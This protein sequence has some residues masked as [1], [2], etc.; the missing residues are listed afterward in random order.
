M[1]GSGSKL[2]KIQT[3]SHPMV[4]YKPVSGRPSIDICSQLPR[5]SEEGRPRENGIDEAY[6]TTD[7]AKRPC[8]CEGFSRAS[9]KQTFLILLAGI[10][11]MNI[12]YQVYWFLR[13]LRPISCNCGETVSEAIANGCRYDSFAAAWL[14]P[15]CRNDELIDRFERAGPNP[16][17]SWPYYGNKNKTQ[18]LSLK[19]VSMLPETGGHFFTTHQWHLVHCAYYWKKMFLAVEQG[20]I[21]EHRYNNLAHL[22]HCEVMS[23]KRDSLDTIVTE[24]GVALH[25]DVIVTAKKHKHDHGDKTRLA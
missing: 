7:R 19:E 13:S 5:D 6:L 24:A 21:I 25:S 22:D 4:K 17:G 3:E 12:G 20:T 14:P 1:L 18:L 16:D 8:R 11:L 10:G 2:L 9:I 23:L 15:A